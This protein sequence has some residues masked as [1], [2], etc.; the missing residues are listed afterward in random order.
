MRAPERPHA[1][2]L[3]V[4]LGTLLGPLDSAVNIAFPHITGAF[5]VPLQMIQWVVICY[6]LTYGSL[7]LVFGKLGDMFGYRRI[8]RAGLILSTGALALCALAP[9]F[10]WLLLFRFLQGVG[11]ALVLSCGPALATAGFAEQER[12]RALGLY[13]MMFAMGSVVGPSLGGLLVEAFGWGAVF[14][15]RVPL[16][17]AALALMGLVPRPSQALAGRPFD[18]V[19]AVLLAAS[20]ALLMFSLNMARPG[21]AGAAAALGLALIAGLGFLAFLWRQASFAEPLIRLGPFRSIGF[22]LLN[23]T[24]IAVFL[25]SF[26]VLLLVPYYLDRMTDLSVTVSGLILA[27]GFVGAV[28]SAPLGGRLAGRIGS[29]RIGFAGAALVAGGT[30]LVGF[31]DAGTGPVSMVAVLLVQGVGLGLFQVAYMD[32]VTGRLPRADRGVAGSLTMLT[33]TIGVVAGA[34]GLTL[35]FDTLERAGGAGG[36]PAEARFLASFQGTF[37]WAGWALVG[38]LALSLIKPRIWFGRQGP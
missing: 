18:G 17:L 30:L 34:T 14:W 6:V 16:A 3:V 2:L 24:S 26:S 22:S 31:W 19:G 15:F 8:F 13:T 27:S 25:V 23:L 38:F 5:G 29:N 11:T 20:L 10:G 12:A 32:M 4:G 37:A 35:I 9:G 1:G 21:G 28:L 7:M 33:R 36:M